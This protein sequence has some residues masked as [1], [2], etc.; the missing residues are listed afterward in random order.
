MCA[1]IATSESQ[2]TK[3]CGY[4]HEAE[5]CF[6]NFT[7]KCTT[8]LQRRLIFLPK[9]RRVLCGERYLVICVSEY[10]LPLGGT[11]A[12][13]RTS[14]HPS[15]VRTD[16][17]CSEYNVMCLLCP[18]LLSSPPHVTDWLVCLSRRN[19]LKHAPCL[20]RVTRSRKPCVQSLKLAMDIVPRLEWDKRIPA[21]C[22]PSLP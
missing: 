12:Q 21:G 3:Q 20:N 14:C 10:A 1:G 18:P 9:V 19:Y 22:L 5:Q 4:L 8:P 15:T 2:L 16:P 11:P 17:N 7:Q 6:H 13:V